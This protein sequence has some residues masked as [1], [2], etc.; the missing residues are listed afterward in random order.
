M[1]RLS[2]VEGDG[3]SSPLLVRPARL[4]GE[5]TQSWAYRTALANAIDMS[6][7]SL[8][9]EQLLAVMKRLDVDAARHGGLVADGDTSGLF[10]GY[11]VPREELLMQSQ[12][13]QA[14]PACLRESRHFPVRWR[15]QGYLCCHIH[16]APMLSRCVHCLQVLTLSAVLTARCRC[17]NDPTCTAAVRPS[18][19]GSVP[20]GQHVW[21]SEGV[22]IASMTPGALATA[23]FKARL[24]TT[25]ARSRRGRDMALMDYHPADHAQAWL[26]GEG[27]AAAF[28]AKDVAVFLEALKHPVHRRAAALLVERKLHAEQASPTIFST[29]SLATWL[30]LVAPRG[31]IA[32]SRG[33]GMSL[34]YA[35]RLD[36]FE[37]LRAAARRWGITTNRLRALL[38][39]GV[40]PETVQIAAG[41]KAVIVETRLV[42]SVCRAV[43][44]EPIPP[45]IPA[46]TRSKWE[47]P[48]TTRILLKRTGLLGPGSSCSFQQRKW[49]PT[50][51]QL[52]PGLRTHVVP[53]ERSTGRT[54]ALS[55]PALY[56]RVT[57]R[58]VG[59]LFV[60][61]QA[62][63]IP[64]Y[65][66][67]A[68]ADF[69][70]LAAPL[71]VLPRLWRESR[72]QWGRRRHCIGQAE[73]F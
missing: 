1:Q 36:G 28:A 15:L 26:K 8:V 63:A 55:H 11:R 50:L 69:D 7:G 62:G 48:R 64:L 23:I 67:C 30:Q 47:T 16:S 6:L 9:G 54:I 49:A 53:I 33:K 18:T 40:I 52:L 61:L 44:G 45:R 14:C 25:V 71:D 13:V 22:E 29:L 73:L 20:W 66:N 60:A 59:D 27:L 4:P 2:V 51:G 65:A 42:D 17:G 38:G 3:S 19:A 32:P 43:L 56:T 70:E 68:D 21:A 5:W 39:P 35:A 10:C 12:S 31:E 37:L 58:A 34:P 24:L 41:R 46:G 57:A 72:T